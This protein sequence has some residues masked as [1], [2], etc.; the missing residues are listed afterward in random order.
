MS[1][2]IEI[3]LIFAIGCSFGWALEVIFRRFWSGNNRSRKWINPGYLN[4]PWLPVYGFGLCILYVL[5]SLESL[6]PMSG[7]P[8]KLM[9]IV[10][11]TLSVTLAVTV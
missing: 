11:M 10:I 3:S 5:S 8:G 6:L 9:L 4:G 2:F 7:V 1:F